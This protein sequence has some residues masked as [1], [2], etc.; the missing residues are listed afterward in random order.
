MNYRTIDEKAREL[1][2]KY[3]AIQ[4]ICKNHEVD[5]DKSYELNQYEKQIYNQYLFYSNLKKHIGK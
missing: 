5:K 4:S 1:H 2:K 3:K